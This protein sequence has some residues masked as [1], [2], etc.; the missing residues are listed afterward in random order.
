MATNKEAK[1]K[2]RKAI[3]VLQDSLFTETLTD[4]Q[5]KRIKMSLNLLFDAYA[6]VTGLP[7]NLSYSD[8][9][10]FLRASSA[11][12]QAI[13]NERQELSNS[14]ATA[15]KILGAVNGVLGLI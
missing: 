5:R 9:A 7:S 15:G 14:L 2:I 13:R 10:G 1:R 8:A 4:Q 3:N 12:L 11:R 6:D